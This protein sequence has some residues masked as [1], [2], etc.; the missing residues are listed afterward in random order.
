MSQ[1][2]GAWVGMKIGQIFSSTQDFTTISIM[3]SSIASVLGLVLMFNLNSGFISPVSQHHR[4]RLEKCILEKR[5]FFDDIRVDSPGF[6]HLSVL[7][8]TPHHNYGAPTTPHHNYR[9]HPPPQN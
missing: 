1:G 5:L 9:T 2:V 6:S 7:L 4:I 3:K 8:T